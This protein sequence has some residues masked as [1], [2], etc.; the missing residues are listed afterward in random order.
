MTPSRDIYRLI[1][2]MAALRT[3][4]TG[5][6]W[7]LEQDFASIAPYTI[8]EAYEVADA[9][10]R[11]D[12]DDL[13]EELGDLLLQVVYHARMAQEEG[14]FEFGDVVEAVTR[15]MIRRHPH[16]FG[17]ESARGAGMAKGMWEK[18]KAEEK[19]EKR[20]ARLS[21]GLDPEDNGKGYLDGI[22]LALPGL[23]RALKLQQKAARVGFDWSEAPP[24]LDKIEE[25][26]G[27][28]RE[29]MESGRAE[30]IKDEFG[31]LLFAMVN[32]GRHLGVEAEDALRGTNDKFRD[33]FHAIERALTQRG[34]TLEGATLDE[35]EALWQDAK[36]KT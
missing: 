8:E 25:E 31:D 16:V 17:D 3:P 21:R 36:R 24:I 27:E 6:P 23:V 14:S 26:I 11:G 15:K 18:I 7:D 10:A 34:E 13:R 1:E 30:R 9:I 28:L 32:L 12:K 20:A 5:C 29:A 2:I 33:R 35:M 22:P 19:A 4:V